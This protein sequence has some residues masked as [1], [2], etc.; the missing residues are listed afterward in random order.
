MRFKE[1]NGSHLLGLR[2]RLAGVMAL[3][4]IFASIFPVGA[5][6]V[7]LALNKP[8]TPHTNIQQGAAEYVVDGEPSTVWYS[9]QGGFTEISFTVDL[10]DR[11][12]V[13]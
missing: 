11:K 1:D 7:N 8:I 4:F 3:L 5:Q 10:T 13:V 6:E 12:S 2:F 9:W